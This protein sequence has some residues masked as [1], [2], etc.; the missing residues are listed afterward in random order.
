[1]RPYLFSLINSLFTT[2]RNIKIFSSNTLIYLIN[3]Y[4][5]EHFPKPF[6]LKVQVPI[7]KIVDFNN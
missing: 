3:H 2:L 7:N 4:V 5:K 6:V 1:M